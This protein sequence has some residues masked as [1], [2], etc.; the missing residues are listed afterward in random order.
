[1]GSCARSAVRASAFSLVEAIM[2][3]GLLKEEKLSGMVREGLSSNDWQVRREA[4]IALGSGALHYKPH[5]A[6]GLLENVLW[7][8]PWLAACEV[9]DSVVWAPLIE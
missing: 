6:D 7:G 1:M 2:V 4:A 3:A 8:P 9:F 5:W